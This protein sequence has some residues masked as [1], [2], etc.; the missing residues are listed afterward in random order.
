MF[1]EYEDE[2]W[3]VWSTGDVLESLKR[4]HELSTIYSGIFDEI[5]R[6]GTVENGSD[7]VGN[8]DS[9]LSSI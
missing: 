4:K 8:G 1:D 6:D 7:I 3:Y 2:E 9:N 5:L